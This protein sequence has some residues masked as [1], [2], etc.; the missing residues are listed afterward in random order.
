M[1][2]LP[3]G[4]LALKEIRR[5]QA[6]TELLIRKRPFQRLVREIAQDVQNSLHRQEMHSRREPYFFRFQ[7]AAILA[8]QEAAEAYF[9]GIFEDA[10]LAA[11]HTKR[12]TIQPKDV[13][14]VKRLRPTTFHP[15]F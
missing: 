1:P 2:P 13:N 12:V 7:S 8:L 11:L 6:S 10:N 9:I 15:R 14:L 4:T 3:P 5:Y